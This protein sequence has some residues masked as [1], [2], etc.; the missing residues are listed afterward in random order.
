LFTPSKVQ[1][2]DAGG[3]FALTQVTEYP[4]E[5]TVKIQ[6]AASQPAEFSIYVRIP[7]WTIDPV[8]SVNGKSVSEPTRPGTFAAIKRMWKHGDRVE[9]ELPMR[10][11]L[12]QVD[13]NHP[14]LMALL[15]GPLVLFAVADAQPTFETNGL[16]QAK[17]ANNSKGD[18]IARSIDGSE[19]PMRP[20]MNIDK[21]N[22]STYVLLKT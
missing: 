22:Y 16:L 8:L 10:L 11:R 7:A 18:W 20:F 4:F 15:H 1:W 13:A 12:E 9:L 5:N 6:V 19:I 21:E 2:S 17:A 14:K 3:R